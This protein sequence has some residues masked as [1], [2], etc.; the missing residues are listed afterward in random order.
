MGVEPP[1]EV[2]G[3]TSKVARG[4]HQPLGVAARHASTL[5]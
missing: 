3:V 4:H 2:A 1:L 5:G